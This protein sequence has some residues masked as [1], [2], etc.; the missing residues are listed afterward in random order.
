MGEQQRIIYLIPVLFMLLATGCATV[1]MASMDSDTTAKTFAL[2]KDKSSIYLYRNELISGGVTMTV[3]L[4]GR[5]VGQTGPKTYFLL[6]VAP[7][8]HE[9]SSVSENVSTL[10]LNTE[11]GKSYYVWQEVKM[12][13]WKAR[14]VLQQVDGE[15]GRKGVTECKLAQSIY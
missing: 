2:K 6:E 1:P 7:G 8:L 10:N 12:G 15:T 11:A 3:S 9:I 4:D 5:V 14:S 13:L